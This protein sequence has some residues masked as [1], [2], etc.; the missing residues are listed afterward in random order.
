MKISL[1]INMEMPTIVGISYLL[2]EKVSCSAEH[3]ICPANKSQ[4]TNC[5]FFLYRF[6]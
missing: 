2:A 3:E 4:I 1:Q 6:S 5:T